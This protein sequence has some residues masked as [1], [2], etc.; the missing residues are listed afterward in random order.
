MFSIVDAY[1][2]S[3]M[4]NAKRSQEKIENVIKVPIY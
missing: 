1:I 4:I 3:K 2:D